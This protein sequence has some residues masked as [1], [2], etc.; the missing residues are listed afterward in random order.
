MA[1][2]WATT[3]S[4]RKDAVSSGCWP[5]AATKAS[6]NSAPEGESDTVSTELPSRPSPPAASS[7]GSKKLRRTPLLAWAGGL[8]EKAKLL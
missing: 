6:S 2:A 3:A 4:Y 7:D 8:G 5:V 1:M